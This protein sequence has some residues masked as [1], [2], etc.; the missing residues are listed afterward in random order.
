ML[1]IIIIIIIIIII[2]F[3]ASV[4]VRLLGPLSFSE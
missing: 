4:S 2:G 1:Q 3:V